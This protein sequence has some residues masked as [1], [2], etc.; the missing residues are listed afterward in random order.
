MKRQQRSSTTHLHAWQWRS[1]QTDSE[2][3]IYLVNDQEEWHDGTY[4]QTRTSNSEEADISD[5]EQSTAIIPS[6]DGII[7]LIIITAQQNQDTAAD[8]QID[9]IIIFFV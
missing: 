8:N 6:Y 2:D 9:T 5:Q 3:D 4:S 1:N 7:W